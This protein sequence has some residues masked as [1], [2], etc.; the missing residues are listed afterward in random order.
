M[1]LWQCC[2]ADPRVDE[3]HRLL[4]H[5][6]VLFQARVLQVVGVHHPDDVVERVGPA[7][8]G[9]VPVE[10]FGSSSTATS[11]FSS[12]MYSPPRRPRG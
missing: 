6:A 7:R 10:V 9:V 4:F 8:A 1:I 2:A 5:L 3:S 12:V 11:R